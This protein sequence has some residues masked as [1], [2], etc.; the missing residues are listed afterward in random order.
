MR[1]TNELVGVL[2][3]IEMRP[4][5][6]Q[7]HQASR[8]KFVMP[9]GEEELTLQHKHIVISVNFSN[10]SAALA[11]AINFKILRIFYLEQP[12]E[13]IVQFEGHTSGIKQVMYT[14]DKKQLVSCSD[15]KTVLCG[16]RP[17]EGRSGAFM[18]PSRL[19]GVS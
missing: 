11:T 5:L 8:Q 17:L 1:V 6:L 12:S 18:S 19:E 14:P 3:S 4:R 2:I 16:T 13:P 7:G 9:S 10:N 15:D